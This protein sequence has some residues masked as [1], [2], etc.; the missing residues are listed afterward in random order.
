M[1]NEQYSCVDPIELLCT[2]KR[3][4]EGIL[5]LLRFTITP[6]HDAMLY[7]NG[8]WKMSRHDD[9]WG[10]SFTGTNPVRFQIL[11]ACSIEKLNDVIKQ[12]VPIRILPYGIHESQLIRQLFFR[13][14]DH[15]KYSK[16]LIE[17]QIIEFKINEDVLKV[18]LESNY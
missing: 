12:V 6:T 16:K 18:L 17:Y 4:P 10:Y 2:I 3:T 5:N 15:T 1:C 13:Q 7:H 9:F 14:R 11:S 8:K